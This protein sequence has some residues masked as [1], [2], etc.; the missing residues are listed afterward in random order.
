MEQSHGDGDPDP[1]R[2]TIDGDRFR[3]WVQEK[4]IPV[5]GNSRRMEPRSIVVMDNA[6]IHGDVEQMIREAGAKLIYTPPYSPDLNPIE[7]MFGSY[8]S[9]LRRYHHSP[10]NIAHFKSLQSVTPQIAR[11][12]YRHCKVPH[13]D[14]FPSQKDIEREE[15][16]EEEFTKTLIVC[17]AATLAI[18]KRIKNSE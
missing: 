12:Y 4:L 2:G 8:K 15:E 9:S 5:L 13:C 6:T 11:S 17:A 3:L 18:I 10:H 7:L 14:H 16:E 1:T